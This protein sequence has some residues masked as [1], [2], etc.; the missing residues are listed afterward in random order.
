M[1]DTTRSMAYQQILDT[2]WRPYKLPKTMGKRL[3]TRN[4]WVWRNS[5]LQGTSKATCQ[6]RLSTT[7]S[8]LARSWWQQWWIICWHYRRSHQ[9]K[10]N[11]ET[12]ARFQV[13]RTSTEPATWYAM[14]TK[15]PYTAWTSICTSNTGL[16]TIYGRPSHLY[17]CRCTATT[18]EW[19]YTK[20][21]YSNS[22]FSTTLQLFESNGNFVHCRSLRTNVTN[23][24]Q[25]PTWWG[26]KTHQ[27]A[28]DR[29]SNWS[30]SSNQ[31]DGSTGTSNYTT[32]DSIHLQD[33]I[34][35]FDW[36]RYKG[37]SHERR[38]WRASSCH[39]TTAPNNTR[40]RR[41]WWGEATERNEQ[42]NGTNEEAW[43]LRRSVYRERRP[44][45]PTQ[46]N[47]QQMGTQEQ[48]TYRSKVQNCSKGLQGRSWG[49]GRHLRK[50]TTFCHPTSPTHSGNG[51][52]VEDPSRWRV[53]S[54]STC[55]SA[56]TF[57]HQ[58]STIWRLEGTTLW[59]LKKAMYG[60]RSSP[61]AWQD[62]FATSMAELGFKRLLSEA[63]VYANST[64]DVYI[65][66]YVDD[67]MVIGDP[68]KVN[69]IF[70]KIQEKMLFKHTGYLDPGEKHYFLGRQ[71]RNEGNYFD[72][73]LDDDYIET[74]L[75]E[76]NM[77]KCN[78]APTPGTAANK[79]TFADSEPLTPDQHKVYRRVV[80]KL[81]WLSFTR[82][83]ISYPTN[84]L[85]RGLHQPTEADWK[86]AK[87][88]VR[89]LRGTSNYTQQL[90]PTTT[91][92]TSK[93][94]L[95]MDIHVDAD[96]AG[97]PSTRKSTTGFVIY[98]LGTP[99]SF[100][101]R[102]QATIALS[103]AESELDAICTGT[104]E[105][106]RLKMFLQESGLASKVNIRIHTD[107]TP[108]KSIATRQGTSKKAKHIDIR[109]SPK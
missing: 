17:R 4:M 19:V 11:Q 75:Q 78:P 70:E 68:T 27:A 5:T 57:G 108:G 90:R 10:N 97:C 94:V 58:R 47:W 76:A 77:T 65:M 41:I 9:S 93:A 29:H 39:T 102:T 84:E 7:Q 60:L 13:W 52:I 50:H 107:S 88:L 1:D 18:H 45:D 21:R 59:R 66:V 96:W 51:K 74:I 91:L 99:V 92:N 38:S 36:P 109:F 43:C 67:I 79:A 53:Y 54:I 101:S 40:Q 61:K 2:L 23:T 89:Y 16:Q 85:A 69:K 34:S 104:S 26:Y 73:M 12:T 81:Q 106:L 49:L 22:S 83:D 33:C 100:G 80:G 14:G 103:S 95:D 3:Q 8:N 15:A 71:I 20:T 24:Y 6:R 56:S 28:A 87:H 82:P 30:Y 25:T 55:T 35:H 63:N 46:R 32:A 37:C 31:H 105:G 48:D 62:Y 44:R 42:G 72:I 98:I 86:K 64:N